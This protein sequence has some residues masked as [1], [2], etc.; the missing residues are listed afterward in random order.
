M[1][2]IQKG[3]LLDPEN[4]CNFI[5]HQ[6]NCEK[7][8]GKGIA[9]IIAGMY[10][11][12]EKVDKEFPYELE[13]RLGRYSI[14]KIQDSFYVVNL[15]GQLF[16]GKPKSKKELEERYLNFRKSITSFLVDLNKKQRIEGRFYK[17]GL[18]YK[19]GSDMA[20]GEWE[21]I[22]DILIDVSEEQKIDLLIYKKESP[23][24]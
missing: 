21:R 19:I 13:Q 17:V 15:Y 16:R 7:I 14:A 18:P 2:H 22:L 8:M 23:P 9:G 4:G 12:A 11:L 6:A 1:I 10:P 5:L 3:D 20:G 24:K